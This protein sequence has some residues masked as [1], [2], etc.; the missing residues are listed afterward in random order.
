MRA[1]HALARITRSPF[2]AAAPV[3]YA[4][5]SAI[6]R[7]HIFSF[8]HHLMPSSLAIAHIHR[9]IAASPH[10]FHVYITTNH[11]AWRIAQ[12]SLQRARHNIAR[13]YWFI[14]TRHLLACRLKPRLS[15][16]NLLF[17][18]F[19]FSCETDRFL[20]H[21]YT[22]LPATTAIHL[23][24]CL[25]ACTS[26]LF[27]LHHATHTK[28][29]EW[30]ICTPA[31]P[32]SP[33]FYWFCLPACSCHCTL[34]CHHLT[35]SLTTSSHTLTLSACLPACSSLHTCLPAHHIT[36]LFSFLPLFLPHSHSLSASHWE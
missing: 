1:D 12:Y 13:L 9:T 11:N 35:A 5:N 21:V 30:R 19:C 36:P 20:Y 10:S 28:L 29:T 16:H 22:S 2:A 7:T 4:L 31:S 24:L 15:A 26:S 23:F 18:L 33:S 6:A 25:P 3:S 14:I 8:A 34:H 27:L 17:F 32:A